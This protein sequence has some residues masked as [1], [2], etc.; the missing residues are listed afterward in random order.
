[1]EVEPQAKET[2]VVHLADKMVDR[3]VVALQVLVLMLLVEAMVAMV[4]LAHLV[5]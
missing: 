1:V 5:L 4:V 2:M 3:V